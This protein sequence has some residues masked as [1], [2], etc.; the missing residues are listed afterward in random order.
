[1]LSHQQTVHSSPH[2]TLRDRGKLQE[3]SAACKCIEFTPAWWEHWESSPP[4]PPEPAPSALAAV[5]AAESETAAAP[6]EIAAAELG[7]VAAELATAPVVVWRQCSCHRC[8]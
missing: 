6:L 2:T 3:R 5:A 7:A 4:G 1:M 8:Q